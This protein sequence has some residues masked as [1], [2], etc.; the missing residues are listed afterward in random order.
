MRLLKSCNLILLLTLFIAL[1]SCSGKYSSSDPEKFNEEVSSRTDIETVEELL[2]VY[3]DYPE[4]EGVP[5]LTLESSDLG[6]GVFH[7]TL[8]HD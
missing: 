2:L 8:I 5:N 1:S 6:A 3:Y 4:N 7:G